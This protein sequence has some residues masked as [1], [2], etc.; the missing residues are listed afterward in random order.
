MHCG[1]VHLQLMDAFTVCSIHNIAAKHKALR[2][3]LELQDI[4][5]CTWGARV[6]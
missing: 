2:A 6:I 1:A 3:A 4:I 5:K